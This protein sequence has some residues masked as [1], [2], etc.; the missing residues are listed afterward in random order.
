M[1]VPM[2]KVSLVVLNKDREASLKK[3]REIGL[4][5]LEKKDGFFRR[6]IKAA[7]SKGQGGK[8]PWDTFLL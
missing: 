5:H 6:L 2:K 8:R 7:G 1:I 3:L 4:I